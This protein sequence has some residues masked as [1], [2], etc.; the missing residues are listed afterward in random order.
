[1]PQDDTRAVTNLYIST[2][3]NLQLM[4]GAVQRKERIRRVLARREV[5]VRQWTI[6]AT[7]HLRL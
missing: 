7:G 1:M 2:S 6:N 5:R 4:V 3:Q